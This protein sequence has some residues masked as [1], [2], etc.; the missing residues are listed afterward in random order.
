MRQARFFGRS[1][2]FL[3]L[4]SL[5]GSASGQDDSTA[6]IQEEHK[7]FYRV[8]SEID[9]NTILE[10]STYQIQDVLSVT[11]NY[12][13]A[14]SSLDAQ[15]LADDTVVQEISLPQGLGERVTCAFDGRFPARFAL[16]LT[17]D[18]GQIQVTA[19]E[20]NVIINEPDQE[21][22]QTV[23]Q[24]SSS[25]TETASMSPVSART[26]GRTSSFAAARRGS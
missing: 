20:A 7:S 16:R 24:P 21:I 6:T 3:V 13:M 15:C 25:P 14:F 18:G 9:F 23:F 17:G 19:V 4:I 26:V 5:N 11:L 8:N 22:G 2:F 10:L 12:N 1:L